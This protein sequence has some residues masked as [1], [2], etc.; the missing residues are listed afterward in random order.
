MHRKP[1][2]AATVD[3]RPLIAH[4]IFRLGVGGLENG[5]V[6]LVNRLPAERFR[7]AIVCLKDFTEF[8]QRITRPDVEVHAIHKKEGHD[9]SAQWRLYRLF[10]RLRPAVVHTRNFGCLEAL[11]PAWLAGVP[12]RVHGEHG[13]DVFDPEGRSR[14]H[15]ILRRAHRVLVDRYVPLSREIEIYLHERVGLASERLTRIYNGVDTARFCPAD[16]VGTE[17]SPEVLAPL[18]PGFATAD[19]IV[20]GTVGRMHGVKDQ[21]NLTHAFIRLCDRV[22]DQAGRLRLV[23]I[24]DGPLREV[25]E[26]L[27][28]AAGLSGQAWLPGARDDVPELLR[29]MTIF[30]LPSQAEGI[31]N[32]IL[33]AMASALPVV[34]TAVGGNPEL[35]A[36]GQTGRL[37]P[38]NDPD[39]LAEAL[40][41]YVRDPLMLQA[42]GRAARQRVEQQFSLDGMMRAYTELYSGVIRQKAPQLLAAVGPV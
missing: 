26:G 20:V 31:S 18:P 6:N 41:A 2:G 4:V 39:A 40:A 9:L 34:A 25:C 37:V 24:G 16:T 30:T 35:V 17:S 11:V 7:H 13:W 36:D 28:K 8:R 38:R 33:E 14:K 27:L 1:S 32:T 29:A 10:R 12:A 5:V 23:M 15:Q 22:P 42:H 3:R 21:E 19:S